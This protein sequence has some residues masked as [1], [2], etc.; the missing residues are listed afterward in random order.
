LNRIS[1]FNKEEIT[2]FY[3]KLGDFMEKHKF[4]PNN[5]YNADETGITTGTD[6]GKMLVEKGQRRV[7][8][9]TSGERGNNITVMCAMNAAGNFIPPMFIFARHL[10]TILN[11]FLYLQINISCY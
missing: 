11:I 7:G 10:I 9:V 6:P 4:L 3:E 8:A 1:A 5:I 2:H